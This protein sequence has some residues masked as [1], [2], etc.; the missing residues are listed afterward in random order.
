MQATATRA[1]HWEYIVGCPV[2]FCL[3][4]KFMT[5]K[6]KYKRY[7]QSQT[8]NICC[9]ICYSVATVTAAVV[10]INM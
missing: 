1:R 7:T 4:D 6:T 9:N 10:G 2:I 5:L 3:T 8:Q